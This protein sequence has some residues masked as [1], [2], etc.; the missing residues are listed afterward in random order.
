MTEDE[1]TDVD[2][3]LASGLNEP[4]LLKRK[5]N[6]RRPENCKLLRVTK[7]NSEIWDIAQKKTR[8]MDSRL[9][10]VQESLVKDII[11]IARLMGTAGE[12]L[13]KEGTMPSPDELWKGLSDSVLLIASATHD[14]NMCR[15]DLFKVDTACKARIV[16]R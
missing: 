8:S 10:K 13:E 4:A 1:Q 14:L 6:I 16:W 5:E 11:P 15:R 7:V 2:S 9:Q 12:V 3:L